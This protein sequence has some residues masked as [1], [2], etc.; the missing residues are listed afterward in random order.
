[1]GKLY[2]ALMHYPVYNKNREVVTTSVTNLDVHDIAR[3]CLTYGVERY[4]IITP[5]E[6]QKRLLGRI[7]R[8][9]LIGPGSEYNT[10]RRD[11]FELVRVVAGLEEAAGEIGAEEG[12][13]AVLVG[14][15]A[16]PRKNSLSFT[17]MV[18][19]INT[20]EKPVLLIMGTGW[21][22]VESELERMDYVLEPIL[23]TGAYNHLSVR[24][25]TSIMLDRLRGRK[26]PA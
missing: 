3:I 14:T 13:K 16:Q 26:T 9:W 5:L 17:G 1:M 11:A 25:A 22:I 4:F 24:S 7:T 8:H 10:T 23:G 19:L 18:H 21:G 12:E 20:L 2:L 15:S 6:K